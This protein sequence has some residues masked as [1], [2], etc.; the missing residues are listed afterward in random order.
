MLTAKVRCK[1]SKT[2]LLKQVWVYQNIQYMEPHTVG[3]LFETLITPKMHSI[4]HCE[5][6]CTTPFV[7]STATDVGQA[8]CR[9]VGDP[10]EDGTEQGPVA[11]RRQFDK[12]MD[13]IQSGQEQGATLLTGGTLHMP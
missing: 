9:T 13:L 12:V 1:Y 11:F 10:F 7:M 3:I 8:W 6:W 2:P 5:N 4:R